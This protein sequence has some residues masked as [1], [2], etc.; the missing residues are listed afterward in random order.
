MFCRTV[1][2]ND[3]D[4]GIMRIAFHIRIRGRHL[5]PE[6]ELIGK[7][8][9]GFAI[10]FSRQGPKYRPLLFTLLFGVGISGKLQALLTGQTRLRQAFFT[11]EIAPADKKE[12]QKTAT[13][14]RY[15]PS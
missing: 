4:I 3:S 13:Y 14:F 9:Q 6:L 8:R 5:E 1:D 12:D 2:G 15:R 7:L 11:C 10:A